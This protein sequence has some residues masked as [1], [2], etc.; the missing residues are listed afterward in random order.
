MLQSNTRLLMFS[1]VVTTKYAIPVHVPL[2]KGL[3]RLEKITSNRIYKHLTG[4]QIRQQ[5]SNID[6]SL[7]IALKL[8]KKGL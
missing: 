8:N 1:M 6:L 4:M 7:S 5:K 3:E 2:Y